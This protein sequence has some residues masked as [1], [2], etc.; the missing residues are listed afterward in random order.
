MQQ[1]AINVER[2]LLRFNSKQEWINKGHAWFS[3][4]KTEFKERDYIAIDSSGRVM[5][6][7]LHFM[8][9][10]KEDAYPVIVYLLSD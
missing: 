6:M 2:E 3:S 9:A 8:N 7:G 4:L 10:E 5:R 1:I